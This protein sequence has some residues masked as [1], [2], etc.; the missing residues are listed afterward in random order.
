MKE[1]DVESYGSNLMMFGAVW[2]GIPGAAV[3]ERCSRELETMRDAG[4]YRR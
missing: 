2:N 1:R 3:G 4:S